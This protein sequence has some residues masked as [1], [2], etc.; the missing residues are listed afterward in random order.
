MDIRRINTGD[1]KADLL[2]AFVAAHYRRYPGG[3]GDDI[4]AGNRPQ[5]FNFRYLVAKTG[6]EH[7]DVTRALT[8]LAGAGV[9][10]VESRFTNP[11]YGVRIWLRK[12]IRDIAA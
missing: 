2:L 1:E 4:L 11:D 3:Q 5:D 9:I 12:P 8:H 10:E 7:G 6:L